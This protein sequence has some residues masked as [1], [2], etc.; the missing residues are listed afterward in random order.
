MPGVV[1]PL[2]QQVAPAEQYQDAAIPVIGEMVNT[3]GV[4]IGGF[5][6]PATPGEIVPGG[7]IPGGTIPGGTIPGGMIPGTVDIAAGEVT[8]AIAIPPV[9]TGDATLLP[10]EVLIE[11]LTTPLLI[12]AIPVAQMRYPE[13]GRREGAEEP[14]GRG[15]ERGRC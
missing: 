12:A 14:Q 9:T 8:G 7:T 15:K 10:V 1:V 4:L 3:G 5:V 6:A 13:P 11:G 2:D